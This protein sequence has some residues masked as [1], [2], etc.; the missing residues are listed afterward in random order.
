MEYLPTKRSKRFPQNLPRKEGMRK[1]SF[2]TVG[3]SYDSPQRYL[4]V[5]GLEE[6]RRAAITMQIDSE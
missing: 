2:Q 1:A 6:K 5:K 4:Y 3:T